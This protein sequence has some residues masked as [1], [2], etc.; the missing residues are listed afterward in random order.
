M[1]VSAMTFNNEIKF[2]MPFANIFSFHVYGFQNTQW[3]CW[4]QLYIWSLAL[5]HDME[6]IMEVLTC[7]GKY[8]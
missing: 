1:G 5:G 3:L 2:K 4:C 7:Y 8:I 6:N